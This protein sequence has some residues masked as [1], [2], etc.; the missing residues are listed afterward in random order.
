MSKIKIVISI[1]IAS[2]ILGVFPSVAVKAENKKIFEN[3]AYYYYKEG[4]IDE[5]IKEYKKILKKTPQNH[6]IHYNLGVLYA[7]QEKYSLAVKE[8]KRAADVD[9][10]VRKDA[11]YNLVI[12]YGKYL[13]NTDQAYKYYE[14][15]KEIQYNK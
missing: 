13:M 14:K 3:F 4:R 9:S 8:F 15:F 5:S 2:L 12:I 11:L 6:K 7:Q 1:A 10:P